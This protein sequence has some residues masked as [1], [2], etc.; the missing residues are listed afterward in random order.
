MTLLLTSLFSCKNAPSIITECFKI[1]ELLKM[2]ACYIAIIFW[3]FYGPYF[4]QYCTTMNL[5]MAILWLHRLK[6]K[7]QKSVNVLYSVSYQTAYTVMDESSFL[8]KH[9]FKTP[10]GVM[11]ISINPAINIKILCQ[12]FEMPI[13]SN[14]C[15]N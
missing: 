15:H 5:C 10:V 11:S 6:T 7:H 1:V 4:K 12:H 2:R 13:C 9:E 14:Q 3:C 8:S